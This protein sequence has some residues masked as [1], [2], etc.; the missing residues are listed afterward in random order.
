MEELIQ[1]YLYDPTVG[2]IAT[3]FI[4][5]GIIWMIIQTIQKNLFSKIKDSDNR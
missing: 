3:L 5:V 2:K 4:G 1:K